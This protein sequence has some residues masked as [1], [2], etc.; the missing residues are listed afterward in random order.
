MSQDIAL[1]DANIFY[2]APLRD[3]FMQLAVSDLFQARWTADIHRARLERTREMMDLATRDCLITGYE[4]LIPSLTL[5]DPD[6]RHVLAAAVTGRCTVIVTWNLVDFPKEVLEPFGIE[7]QDPD[8][9]LAHQLSLSP[10]RFCAAV[11]KVRQRLKNP[12][13]TTEQYL[14]ILTRQRLVATVA[15]LEPFSKQI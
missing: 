11:R 15:A 6:D 12:P 9:F 8:S 3:L 1:L 2:P 13:Y 4:P 10:D 7:A 14:T 5:P